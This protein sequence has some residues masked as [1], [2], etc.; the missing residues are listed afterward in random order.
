MP[1]KDLLE[2]YNY[3]HFVLEKFEPWMRFSESPQLGQ[4]APDFP[5]YHIDGGEIKLS[6]IWSTNLLTIIEFG[7]F[8]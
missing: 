5:L 6:Q 4:L 1:D 8:T 3:D 7:S 2:S